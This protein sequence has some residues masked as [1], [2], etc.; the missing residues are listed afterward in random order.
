M[1]GIKI[2]REKMGMSRVELASLIGV[3]ANNIWRYEKGLREPNIDTLRQIS[4]A[5][6]CKIDVLVNPTTPPPVAQKK[7][8]QG[9]KKPESPQAKE[10]E[11]DPG[12]TQQRRLIIQQP[13]DMGGEILLYFVDSEGRK[14]C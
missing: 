14:L 11:T 10:V 13:G 4:I 3:G 5:L 9:Q 1:I 2:R 8:Q 7:S 6:K 12:I